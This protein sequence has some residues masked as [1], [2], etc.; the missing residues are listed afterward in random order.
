MARK[1]ALLVVDVQNDFTPGG[2]LAVPRG[3]EVV[4]LLNRYM[5]M[6]GVAGVPVYTS[7]DWHPEVSKHFKE[8][9]GVWP[10]HCI[11]GTWGAEFHP[12]L[13]RPEDAITISKGMD[14]ERDSY[15]AFDAL[16]ED[17]TPLAESLR[18]RGVEHIFMGGLAT[19]Y[20]VKWSALEAANQGFQFTVLLDASLGVNL[21]PH[22]SEIAIAEMVRAGAEVAVMETI[23]LE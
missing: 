20:C 8:H 17:G 5:E 21:E 18:R 11:Q 22:D 13:R 10:P 3:D 14:P 16:E 9:G 19:D 12:D 7:R 15:S 2:A 6:F 23:L 4:P 1:S